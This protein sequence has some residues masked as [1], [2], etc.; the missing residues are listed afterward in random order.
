M[1]LLEGDITDITADGSEYRFSA[2]STPTPIQRFKIVTS[3]GSI[4]GKTGIADG[5][6]NVFNSNE[7]VFIE[8]FS[9]QKGTFTLYDMK[10]IAVKAAKCDANKVTYISTQELTPGA[11]LAKVGN[12]IN[13]VTAKII[14]R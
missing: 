6:L 4:T 8:N 9:D 2:E 1:D 12:G 3:T 5:K 11:Y 7:T 10:G 14:I 13:Q